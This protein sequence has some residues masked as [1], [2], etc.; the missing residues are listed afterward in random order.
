[1]KDKL[2]WALLSW[3]WKVDEAG[4][5][6]IVAG[7]EDAVAQIIRF[8]GSTE[9]PVHAHVRSAYMSEEPPEGPDGAGLRMIAKLASESVLLYSRITELQGRGTRF[10]MHERELRKRIVEL[11]GEDPGPSE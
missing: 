5:S 11:G 1:M 10:V 8:A 6:A 9:H 7:S 4:D 3:K 2:A